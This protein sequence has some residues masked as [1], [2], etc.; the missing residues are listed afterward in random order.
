[1][2]PPLKADAMVT[3][4]TFRDDAWMACLLEVQCPAAGGSEETPVTEEKAE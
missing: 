3:G 4:P 2:N 1:M